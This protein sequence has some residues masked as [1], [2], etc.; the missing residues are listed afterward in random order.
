MDKEKRLSF[1]SMVLALVMTI[2]VVTPWGAAVKAEEIEI[3]PAEQ[4]FIDQV[5][6]FVVLNEDKQ[7]YLMPEASTELSTEAYLEAIRLIKDTNTN[8]R[9]E[10]NRMT[11]SLD[12]TTLEYND[13]GNE[14]PTAI[15]TMALNRNIR[16]SIAWHGPVIWFSHAAVQKFK[17]N[18]LLYGAGV[19]GVNAALIATMIYYGVTPPG[20]LASLATAIATF[21]AWLF[22][23]RDK[24][25]GVN[26]RYFWG[27]TIPTVWNAC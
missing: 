4:S 21:G 10:I 5:S 27:S 8:I 16:I 20:W 6:P 15:G 7:Y 9:R 2:T 25:C 22:I 12:G 23:S 14:T 13:T 24:G 17:S 11:T 1:I 26:V 19:A 18:I 3:P